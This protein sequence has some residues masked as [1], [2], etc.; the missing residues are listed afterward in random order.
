MVYVISLADMLQKWN[1]SNLPNFDMTYRVIQS[2][3]IM[4]F[5]ITY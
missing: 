1:N 2:I 5:Y 4:N 3:A